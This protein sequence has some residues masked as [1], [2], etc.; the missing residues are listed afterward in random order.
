MGRQPEDD[1]HGEDS[2]GLELVAGAA[3]LGA[4]FITAEAMA[5]A[6]QGGD[7][8]VVLPCDGAVPGDQV[9]SFLPVGGVAAFGVRG[10][11]VAGLFDLGGRFMVRD[12]ADLLG[13]GQVGGQG[14]DEGLPWFAFAAG[15]AYQEQFGVGA[16]GVFGE[17]VH[18]LGG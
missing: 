18:V 3:V 2:L 17:V 6:A 16:R 11:E 1:L 14:F 12:G 13:P 7:A 15:V 4:V 8:A 5:G 10:L 9:Q